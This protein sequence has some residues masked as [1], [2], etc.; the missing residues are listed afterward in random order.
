MTNTVL[1]KCGSHRAR[2]KLTAL[3]GRESM[4]AL[5]SLYRDVGTGG[6]FR[7]PARYEREAKAI[8]G[9]SGMRDGEDLH[10]CWQTTEKG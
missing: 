7:I 4:I 1:V 3:V 5:F 8:T 10:K 2:N 6:A 9:V